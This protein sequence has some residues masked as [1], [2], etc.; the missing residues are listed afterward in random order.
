MIPQGFIQ[1]L[2]ARADI[3]DVVGRAV[4][5]KKAGIN[6]KGLCPFH[7]EKSPSFIVSPTRQTYH[8]F[9]CGVHGNAIGF[10]MEHSG[11]GFIDAVKELAQ[12]LG[13]EVPEQER[14]P[15]ERERA[16]KAREQ[17]LASPCQPPGA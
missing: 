3:V 4:Q 8:C 14:S 16:A 5:L 7:G 6:Y 13:V 9:G 17:Q 11:L 2:L 12:T 15:E 1:D 10:L